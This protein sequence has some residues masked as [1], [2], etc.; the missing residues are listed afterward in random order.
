MRQ[1]F[2]GRGP[3]DEVHQGMSGNTML[4]AQPSPTYDQVLPNLSALSDRLVVLF[5]RSA[6]DV[7]KAKMLFVNREQYREVVLYRQKVCP[8]S[9]K[10]IIDEAAIEKLLDN[11]VPNVCWKARRPCRKQLISTPPYRDLRAAF[12]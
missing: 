5:C 7:S 10:S 12:P 4:I 3:D 11:A 1:L 2:L 6:D 9:A 8:T